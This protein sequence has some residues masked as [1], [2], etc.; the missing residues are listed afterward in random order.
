[1][2]KRDPLLTTIGG[3][4][5][6]QYTAQP[7]QDED[8]DMVIAQMEM[9]DTVIE[10]SEILLT[11]LR[12]NQADAR[13]IDYLDTVLGSFEDPFPNGIPLTDW[14]ENEEQYQTCLAEIKAHYQEKA[15]LLVV[16]P[17][18]SWIG[19]SLEEVIGERKRYSQVAS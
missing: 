5:M 9:F 2:R 7:I 12:N 13:I 15:S 3:T 10:A 4:M 14:S 11:F 17:D 8:D 18:A 19:A 6:N 1:V 16:S